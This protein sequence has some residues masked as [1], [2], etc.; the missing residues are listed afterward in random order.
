[1]IFVLEDNDDLRELFNIILAEESY[2]VQ[3]FA[4]A[5][6]FRDYTGAYPD[7]YLLDIML[8]DGDGL[9]I[10][11]EIKDNTLT[12]NIPVIMM[13]AHVDAA[14]AMEESQPDG[15]IAK[16]FDVNHFANYINAKL[17]KTG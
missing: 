10:C 3:T 14:S 15:F 1:M 6:A 12:A 11:K 9:T 8:P 2:D 17:L 16:P 5:A 13:S 7:L 4:S